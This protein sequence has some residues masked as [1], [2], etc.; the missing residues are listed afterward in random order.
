MDKQLNKLLADL[1]VEYLTN[2]KVITGILKEK[3]SLLS[4]QN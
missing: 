4:M 3:I 2:Y 1:V